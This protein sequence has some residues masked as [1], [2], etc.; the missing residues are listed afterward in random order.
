MQ[1][2]VGKS[3]KTMND[4]IQTFVDRT[5]S[6]SPADLKAIDEKHKNLVESLV[7]EGSDSKVIGSPFKLACIAK[8]NLQTVKGQVLA[9]LLTAKV[10]T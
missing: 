7:L 3:M 4:Y 1:L 9:V 10:R 8:I 5:M 2:M 6:I